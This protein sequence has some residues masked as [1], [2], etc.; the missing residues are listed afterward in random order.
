MELRKIFFHSHMCCFWSYLSQVWSTENKFVPFNSCTKFS[1]CT[2][3]VTVWRGSGNGFL[4]IPQYISCLNSQFVMIAIFMSCPAFPYFP[5]NKNLL[6]VHFWWCLS[7]I[8]YWKFFEHLSL[9][10][11][12][13]V[14]GHITI[15]ENMLQGFTYNWKLN[16]FQTVGK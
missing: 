13:R 6:H 9:G 11:Y 7:S 1:Q 16:V 10:H 4:C 14:F 5:R 3:S 2:T 12:P 8:K 15:A